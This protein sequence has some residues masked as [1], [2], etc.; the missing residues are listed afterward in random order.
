MFALLTWNISS[1][2]PSAIC[3]PFFD[4][5]GSVIWVKVATY[6]VVT[7][8]F[9]S[10]VVITSNNTY[11][12]VSLRRFQKKNTPKLVTSDHLNLSLLIQLIV[13]MVSNTIC[14]LPSGAIYITCLYLDKYPLDLIV[15]TT[16]VFTCVSATIIPIVFIF[17]FVKK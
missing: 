14:W 3:S 4:P 15:W 13:L 1:G 8:Q 11:L 17:K 5:T 16:V 2:L 9:T 12:M 7:L 10:W 6:F